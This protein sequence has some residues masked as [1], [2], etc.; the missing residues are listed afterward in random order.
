[1][2]DITLKEYIQRQI[3]A[4]EKRLESSICDIKKE[5][6][7]LEDRVSN[8]FSIYKESQK[9]AAQ[10]MDERLA[11]MNEFRDQ[12]NKERADYIGRKELELILAPLKEHRSHQAGEKE[13][14]NKW[15]YVMMVV[16]PTAISLIIRYVG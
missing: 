15:L 7:R 13:S 4:L 11:H 3:D 12:I 14:S 16:I 8:H 10:V 9:T 2:N 6:L 5:L 1:M